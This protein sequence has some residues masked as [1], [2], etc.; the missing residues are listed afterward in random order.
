MQVIFKNE[1]ERSY[2]KRADIVGIDIYVGRIRRYMKEK[3]N[4]GFGVRSIGV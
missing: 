4:E 2:D 3:Y 1:H